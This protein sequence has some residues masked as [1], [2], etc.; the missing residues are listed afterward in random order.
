MMYGFVIRSAV[1]GSL[2]AGWGA[3]PEEARREAEADY[4]AHVL[5]GG[6]VRAFSPEEW[7]SPEVARMRRG[8]SV[9]L[10]P[11]V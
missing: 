2:L 5:R 7:E 11:G 1:R 9:S 10:R 6:G 3:S 8:E 4:P